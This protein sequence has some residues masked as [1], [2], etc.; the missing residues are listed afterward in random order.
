MLRHEV[1]FESR[2]SPVLA[3]RGAVATSHPLA[4]QTGVEIL[5]KDDPAR[6]PDTPVA[7]R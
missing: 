2:R 7:E 3:R 5:P 4:A 6:N 1:K